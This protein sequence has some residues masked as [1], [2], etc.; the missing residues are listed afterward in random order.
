[1]RAFILLS[2]TVLLVT[3]AEAQN[4]R[5]V[6]DSLKL[7]VRSGP[8]VQNRIIRMLES[9]TPV[10]VLERQKGWSKVRL[11]SGGEAWILDRFLMDQPSARG[12]LEAARSDLTTARK[13]VEQLKQELA[14]VTR[15]NA[16]LVESRDAFVAKAN[17]LSGELDDIKRTASSAI[18]VRNENQRLK[19]Q[20]LSLTAQ[21]DALDR[22]F[23]VLRDGRNRDWFIAGAGVLF[24][25]MLLGLII[26][27][28]R[29]KRRRSWSEL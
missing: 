14:K 20:T 22:D 10:S 16:E 26:P 23:T 4:R 28:I 8:G 18:A 12:Q 15:S 11:S 13:Q 3:S 24:G 6:T 19:E 25:G 21:L 27:R 9:G 7:E 2:L 1:M 29:W 5:Y 17:D